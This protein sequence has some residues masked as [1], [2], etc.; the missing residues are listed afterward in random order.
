M[1]SIPWSQD[2]HG[3]TGNKQKYVDSKATALA[4]ALE[5]K[6]KWLKKLNEYIPTGIPDNR[7]PMRTG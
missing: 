6:S 2:L 3:V 5:Y 4:I 7:R 1:Q